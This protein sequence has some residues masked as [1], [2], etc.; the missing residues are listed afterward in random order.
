MFMHAKFLL[1]DFYSAFGMKI[2]T[3]KCKVMLRI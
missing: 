1:D 2:M 3:E